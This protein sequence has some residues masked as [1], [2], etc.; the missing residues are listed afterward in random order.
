MKTKHQDFHFDLKKLSDDGSFEGYGSI[1]GNE[2]FGGDIVAKGAF[3][4][5]IAELKAKKRALPVLWQHKTDQPIGVY[6]DV[7]EDEKGLY[8]KGKLLLE[9][10]KAKEA[11]ALLKAKAVSGLS[12]GYG[13]DKY[14]MDTESYVRTLTKLNLFEVSLVTFP[15]NDEARVEAVK[16]KLFD[17]KLP[18]LKEFEN[19]LRESGFS[20]TQAVA[21][22]NNGMGY[23]LRSES[24]TDEAKNLI[25]VLDNFKI[26]LPQ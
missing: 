24:V 25:E 10:Q 11:Y 8:V 2:D 19:F 5:S 6:E 4:D 15:M 14:E 18:S 7:V 23:L 26:Q 16:Q 17:G 1:F 3:A 12:I 13:V 20:K 21:I 22:A 9:V